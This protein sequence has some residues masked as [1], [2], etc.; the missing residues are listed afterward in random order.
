MVENNP[1]M[2]RAKGFNDCD[3]VNS[4]HAVTMPDT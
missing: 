3:S 2:R 4:E 1:E